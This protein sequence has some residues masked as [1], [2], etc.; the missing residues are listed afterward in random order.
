MKRVFC[1]LLIFAILMSFAPVIQ[2]AECSSSATVAAKRALANAHKDE[3]IPGYAETP[4]N[5]LRV[6][7]IDEINKKILLGEINED[8][9]YSQLESLGVYL[10]EMPVE[11]SLCTPT[12]TNTVYSSDRPSPSDLELSTVSLT[13]DGP[14]GQWTLSGTGSWIGDSWKK[15]AVHFE[16]YETGETVNVGGYDGVGIVLDDTSGS[17][18]G[19]LVRSSLYFNGNR[20]SNPSSNDIEHGAF[21]LFQDYFECVSGTMDVPNLQYYG[22]SFVVSLTYSSEFT[23]YNG[24]AR[25]QYIHTWGTS[26]ILNCNAYSK[27]L[28]AFEVDI[29][30][31]RQCFTCFSPN[32]LRF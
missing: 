2:G 28:S 3:Y 23:N 14:T 30:E 21:F 24:Y 16:Y 17:F 22:S 8:D 10:L 32:Y 31:Q 1:I 5:K 29:Y 20:T 6:Q 15:G 19:D 25:I 12:S 26:H 4:E 11:S 13:Y 18:D 7:H 9:G 27:R